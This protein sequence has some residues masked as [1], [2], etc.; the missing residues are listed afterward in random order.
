[1]IIIEA[2][3]FL[4]AIETGEARFPTFRDGLAVGEVIDAAIRSSNTGTWVDLP[5]VL[6]GAS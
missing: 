3:D 1:M 5:D 4:E 2:K 6:G